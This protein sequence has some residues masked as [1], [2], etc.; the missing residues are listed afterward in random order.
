VDCGKINKHKT[1]QT[2]HRESPRDFT[3][4]RATPCTPGLLMRNLQ[5]SRKVGAPSNVSRYYIADRQGEYR[6]S[7]E[8]GHRNTEIR[9]TG[10]LFTNRERDLWCPSRNSSWERESRHRWAQIYNASRSTEEHNAAA[11]DRQGGWEVRDFFFAESS[12]GDGEDEPSREHKR[13][14]SGKPQF[15]Q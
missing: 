1:Y 4:P 7:N 11:E 14:I 13:D 10:Q 15:R 9:T 8:A 3:F 2:P 6:Y 5:R 12:C